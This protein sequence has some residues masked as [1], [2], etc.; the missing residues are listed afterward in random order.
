M[1]GN[2]PS[3][4]KSKD[5]GLE[6]EEAFVNAV[7]AIRKRE[8]RKDHPESDSEADD[9]LDDICNTLKKL[10]RDELV[11]EEEEVKSLR[12]A[13]QKLEDKAIKDWQETTKQQ[14]EEQ[15]KNR[16]QLRS[17]L[18]GKLE[19]AVVERILAATFPPKHDTS[20]IDQP[21][22]KAMDPASLDPMQVTSASPAASGFKRLFG[23]GA[24]KRPLEMD[25]ELREMVSPAARASLKG[26]VFAYDKEQRIQKSSMGMPQQVLTKR[27]HTSLASK[28]TNNSATLPWDEYALLPYALRDSID[29][30]QRDLGD[31][32]APVHVERL[33]KARKRNPFKRTVEQLQGV[34]IIFYCAKHS[35]AGLL[36]PAPVVYFGGARRPSRDREDAV[37]GHAS[38]SRE[39]RSTS[40]RPFRDTVAEILQSGPRAS[41]S[42]RT[43]RRESSR[44]VQRSRDHSRSRSRTRRP[45]EMYPA[46]KPRQSRSRSRTRRRSPGPGIYEAYKENAYPSP[47][48]A[49]RRRHTR[50]ETKFFGDDEPSYIHGSP[51]A[52][53]R[54]RDTAQPTYLPPYEQ[55]LLRRSRASARRQR[56]SR[57]DDDR[58][59]DGRYDDYD[60]PAGYAGERPGAGKAEAS[61]AGQEV[62]ISRQRVPNRGRSGRYNAE[63]SIRAS[64]AFRRGRSKS[65]GD[66]EAQK[67]SRRQNQGVQFAI[68][69]EV[70]ALL[71]ELT[72]APPDTVPTTS[73]QMTAGA[74]EPSAVIPA[75]EH[76]PSYGRV[77]ESTGPGNTR[78]YVSYRPPA[79]EPDV[80][81][82]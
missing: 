23:R 12:I 22:M 3:A 20:L 33:I 39:E 29:D 8:R 66:K 21:N 57:Y 64:S 19:D 7:D 4:T 11:R 40:P 17:E 71:S 82:S 79:A 59:D 76:E 45:S 38:Y 44:H 52:M 28:S 50:T 74:V 61:Y 56:S 30:Q 42:R 81:E 16:A 43:R 49:N 15:Q 78:D 48:P 58:Y 5:V 13:L 73:A 25:T 32:W 18:S 70:S 9:N 68:D 72:T 54:V 10:A 34:Y 41:R 51:V 37:S 69:Q 6:A 63:I 24:I 62:G 75:E 55:E 14:I 26:F 2:S 35:S 65:S 47:P 60:A 53:N 1:Y 46:Y 27:L 80:E 77:Q 31:D 36:S 67:S